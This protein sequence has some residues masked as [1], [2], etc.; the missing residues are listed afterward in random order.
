MKNKIIKI[1]IALTTIL[2]VESCNEKAPYPAKEKPPECADKKSLDGINQI[3]F[4]GIEKKLISLNK[5]PEKIIPTIKNKIEVS[6]SNIR[7]EA[8][9]ENISK[10]T[11]AA[12]A[13]INFEKSKS[14]ERILKILKEMQNIDFSK[15]NQNSISQMN[16]YGKLIDILGTETM[17]SLNGLDI[18]KNRIGSTI[19]YTSTF[20]FNPNK[21]KTHYMQGLKLTPLIESISTL[22]TAGV[23]EPSIIDS[24]AYTDN[25][26]QCDVTITFNEN[27]TFEVLYVDNTPPEKFDLKHSKNIASGNYKIEKTKGNSTRNSLT[28]NY[29]SADVSEKCNGSPKNLAGLSINTYIELDDQKMVFFDTKNST[30]PIAEIERTMQ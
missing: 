4:S 18:E 30:E 11:C 25:K 3:L 26:T 21:E 6:I 17:P 1:F 19:N 10:Y 28:F 2:L 9:D 14:S 20:S 23:F 29:L 7:I 8:Y 15:L 24:W 16:A 12:D 5:N 13:S 22:Y 27:K